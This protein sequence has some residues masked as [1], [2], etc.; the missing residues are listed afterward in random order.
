M[1]KPTLMPQT[2]PQQRIVS[3]PDLPERPEPFDSIVGYDEK[4]PGPQ[5][6]RGPRN[7]DYLGQLQWSWGRWNDRV[8]AYYLHKGRQHWMLWGYWFDD[9]WWKWEW[10]A[11]GYVPR[12]QAT[13]KQAA[14]HL[15]IDYLRWELAQYELDHFHWIAEIGDLDASEWRMIGI[16]VWPE[17]SSKPSAED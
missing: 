13:K 16:E 3:L 14:I 10:M 9:N 12:V 5:Y 1:K 7:P 8:V 17:A 15:V 2:L 11:I 4:P 6:R